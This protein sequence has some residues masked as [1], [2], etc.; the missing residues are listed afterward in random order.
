[1]SLSTRFQNLREQERGGA[2]GP[3]ILFVLLVTT[4]A[5]GIGTAALSLPAPLVLP[6]A[7]IVLLILAAAVA[8]IAW[9][10]PRVPPEYVTYW[11]ISGALT[12]IGVFAALLGD[13]E[14]VI[15]LLEFERAK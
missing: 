15:P 13:P 12:L 7:S 14:Q 5:I 9:R 10:L 8:L 1:M 2:R 11:D 6:I 4:A 3:Q